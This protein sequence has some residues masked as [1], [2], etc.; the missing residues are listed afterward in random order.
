MTVV[1]RHSLCFIKYRP[2]V[3][4]NEYTL[5]TEQKSKCI[6]V[7]E[8]SVHYAVD[9]IRSNCHGIGDKNDRT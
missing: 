9:I 1:G 6:H 5:I 4:E 2:N 8:K 3:N 7:R